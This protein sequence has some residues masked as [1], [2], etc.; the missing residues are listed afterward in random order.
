MGSPCRW[1]GDGAGR[2]GRAITGWFLLVLAVM[3]TQAVAVWPAVAQDTPAPFGAASDTILAWGSNF[4]GEL[5]NGTTT[6][7]S[8]PVAVSLPADTAAVAIAAG[9]AHSVA[10][11]AAGTVLAWGDNSHG[12][13]GDGTGADSL[14][15]VGVNLPAGVTASAVAA[16]RDHSVALTSAGAVLAWGG[17]S[18]GQ[19]GDGTVVDR[20]TPVAVA[21]PPS[22]TVTAV[23]AGATHSVALT[24]AGTALAW[25]GNSFG[26]LGDGTVVDRSTPVAVALPPSTTVTAVA[27]GGNHSVA[28]TSAGTALAWGRNFFGQLGDGTVVDRSTPTVVSLPAGVTASA[29]A[30]GRIHSLALTTAGGVLAWGNNTFG[31]LGDGTTTTSSSPVSVTLPAATTITAISAR[32]S[33]HSVAMTSAGAALSWG[34][35]LRGQLG[36]GTTTNRS[37]PVDVDLPAGVTVTSIAAGDDHSLALTAPP[38][39]TTTLQVTPANPTADQDITLTAT[40]TCNVDTP[41]GTITFR[42]NTTTL[43]TMP[44]TTSATHTTTLPTGTHTLTAHHTSTNTCPNSQSPPTTITINP[45]LPITGPTLTTTTGAATLSILAGATLIYAARRL[46]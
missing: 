32:D 20:S 39:S 38:T 25:G 2:V 13:L 11:T 31:Q 40:V 26:Q 45:D 42:T 43:A 41:T 15:P 19:L 46:A 7:S 34:R 17:N 12:Q 22:T 4:F 30:A 21:L 24:S 23:A 9:D 33:Q 29:V 3:V 18:F 8:T 35:N 37:T 16:G 1:A 28:L 5:G 10:L 44:L 36:D 27:A 6:N 14:T